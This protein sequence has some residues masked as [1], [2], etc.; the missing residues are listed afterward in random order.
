MEALSV[1]AS[2]V[3]VLQLSYQVIKYITSARGA[4]A[5][6]NRLR[7]EIRA[8]SHVLHQLEDR[9]SDSEQSEQW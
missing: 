4:A 8:V 7:D 1:A 6:R 5:D 3:A 9:E 2:V